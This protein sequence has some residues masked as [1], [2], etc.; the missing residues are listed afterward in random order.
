MSKKHNFRFEGGTNPLDGT[1][2]R[3][4]SNDGNSTSNYDAASTF[5]S[6]I[7]TSESSIDLSQPELEDSHDVLRKIHRQILQDSVQNCTKWSQKQ[8]KAAAKLSKGST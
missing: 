1:D 6:L 5:G 2:G 8:L 4:R 3:S 7:H